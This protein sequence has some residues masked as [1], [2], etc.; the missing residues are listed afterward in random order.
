MWEGLFVCFLLTAAG[1]DLKRSRVD[2]MIYLIFGA[3]AVV[4]GAYKWAVQGESYEVLGHLAGASV[5]AV[6]LGAG[7][8]SRGAI[9]AG[10]GLFFLVSG[11]ML[12]FWENLALLCYGT[13]C[14][15]IFCLI[16]FVWCKVMRGENTGK[17]TV[18]FL[19]FA[20]IPGLWLAARGLEGFIR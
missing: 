18:P 9:G 17:H 13:L 7:M 14:C 5:G 16:Y 15:G 1:Q 8:A 6:L 20:V 2:I 19:P 12:G 10:D 4:L 11:L 3:S